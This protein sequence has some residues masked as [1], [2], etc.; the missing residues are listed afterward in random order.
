MIDLNKELFK[1]GPIDGRPIYPDFF[2][3]SF[4]KYGKVWEVPWP[5]SFA[6]FEDD[7][8]LF[9]VEYWKL[10]DY[11]EKLFNAHLMDKESAEQHFKKW[12]ATLVRLRELEEQVNADLTRLSDEELAG[13]W[14]NLCDWDMDF[15]ITGLLPEFSNWGGE[16]KLK[17]LLEGHEAFIELFEKL[18]TP[19]DLSFYQT[20]ELD[21][22]KVKL[23]ETTL[24]EHQKKYY[25]IRNS[26]GFTFEKTKEEFQ[27]ELNNISLNEAKK[28]V[29]AIEE[30]KV[31][32]LEEKERV[33]EKYNIADEVYEVARRL[34]YSIWWQDYRKQFIFISNHVVSKI[35]EE[36]GKRKGIPFK[37]LCYYNVPE[38]SALANKGETV[39]NAQERYR[40]YLCHYD[41]GDTL[42]YHV[43]NEARRMIEPYQEVEI[44]NEDEASGIVVSQGTG[45]VQGKAR[46]LLT[47]RNVEKMKDGE[48][49][50]APMTSPDYVVAMR[51]AS[52]IVTDEGGMTSH[53]AIV[54]REL[55]LPCIVGTRVATKIFKDGDT[56]E[57][58]TT[59]GVVRRV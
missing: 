48:I 59:K 22:L 2:N 51:K 49:L 54:S 40:G 35:L 53:A 8:V 6:Y 42:T 45:I 39:E 36:L 12:E 56:I 24:E 28:K 19:E 31:K 50:L 3:H 25:W 14:N 58:D 7:K 55:G 38:I 46:I 13:V 4:P 33:R 26:Y 32:V 30:Y 16:Q 44:E 29:A 5:E 37:E 41:E 47:P 18:S 1:W 27:E 20:E 23:G 15:W 57:V 11:G 21:L 9:V 17:R 52:A 34:S 10:R 43:G